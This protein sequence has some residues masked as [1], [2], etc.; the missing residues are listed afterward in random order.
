ML[1]RPWLPALLLFLFFFGMAIVQF[2]SPDLPDNDGFYHIKL[3]WLMRTEGLKP[4]F[5]W[6]PL[7]ILNEGEFYDHHFL[8]HIALI[9][10]TF[11]DLRVGAKWAAVTFSAISFLSVW[12][13]F[14]R[15]KI[16]LSWLWALALLGISDAFLFRMSIT[17]AQSL[18]LAVLAL[19][20]AWILEGKYKHLAVLS[21]LYVWM[22]DAFPLMLA[23]AGLHFLAVL[24]IER[25]L[26]FRPLFW[27]GIGIV[28]GLIINPYFPNNLIFT[29][30]HLLPKLLDATSVSVGNEWYPYDTG[31]LLENSLP[32][33]IAFVSGAL[34]LGLAGRKMD[35]RTA[36]SFMITLLFGL[37][38]F[39]A[40]RFVEY[41]PPFALI[42]SVFAWAPL[43]TVGRQPAVS[44]SKF[45]AG[46]QA[47]L[48]I[49]LLV[50]AVSAGIVKTIPATQGSL[51]QSKPYDLYEGASAWL[52]QNTPAG[53]RV[54]QTD[55]DDFPRLFFYN[56]H[57]TYL[58]GLDPT[59]MQLYD[60]DLYDE[61]VKITRGEVALPSQTILTRFSAHY[62][63]T[64]LSHTGFLRQA[65]NDPGLVEAY[66]DGQAV[67]FE[68]LVP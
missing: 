18:S 35:L 41:F 42:F 37:M 28:S 50:I 10:F 22:Y 15:Q 32:A 68:V 52:M 65:A 14:H 11:G 4:N 17:R 25:R 46:L 29:Y 36:A 67:I 34:A 38:L 45:L 53:E 48:H 19:G 21:F 3:A 20:L 56:T 63:H 40:R 6:L 9:P 31:Q 24:L 26:E 54:F 16:P 59:Y 58:V 30:H 13:L 7:S 62:V 43:F 27:A 39:K 33:L 1:K 49:I 66:R 60:K 23:I 57:N 44:T 61:W 51:A 55:W 5:I 47:N 8:F 2:A 64:D 12:Y